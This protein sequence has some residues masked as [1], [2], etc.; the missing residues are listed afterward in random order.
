MQLKYT[1]QK[2]LP[3][4]STPSQLGACGFSTWLGRYI[5]ENHSLGNSVKACRP[6][7]LTLHKF[8]GCGRQS[9]DSLECTYVQRQSLGPLVL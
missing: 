9:L 3:Q 8:H 6:Y 7:G 4:S 2:V 5:L 1:A